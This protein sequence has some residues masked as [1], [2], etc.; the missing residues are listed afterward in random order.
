MAPVWQDRTQ[1]G[2]ELARELGDYA[3]APSAIVLGI[4]RGGVE[5]ARR[6][7]DRLHVPLD[8]VVVRKIGAPGAPEFAAGAVDADGNVY[9]NPYALVTDEW[10]SAAAVAEHA[11]IARRADAYRGGRPAPDVTGKTVLVVDDGIATGLTAR[12]AVRWLRSRGAS[13]VVIAAPVIAPDTVAM[14]AADADDVV[15]LESPN[16]FGAVGAYYADFPQLADADVV[17]LLAGM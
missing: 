12:A 2:D 5:V 16:G 10:L 9:A 8:I 6:V 3:D 17:R 15:A 1:A 4:P 7:A 11:E 13:H 14:L